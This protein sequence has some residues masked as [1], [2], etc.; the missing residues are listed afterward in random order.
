MRR[1]EEEGEVGEGKEREV[2][3]R[4]GGEEFS[5]SQRLI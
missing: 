5:A 4:E 3:G 2:K 1:E